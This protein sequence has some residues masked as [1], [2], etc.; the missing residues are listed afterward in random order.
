MALQ[1]G[2]LKGG[3]YIITNAYYQNNVS[4]SADGS[5]VSNTIPGYEDAPTRKMLWTVTLLLNGSYSIRNSLSKD[6][7]AIGPAVPKLGD[8]IVAKQEEQ[9]WEIKETGVKTRYVIS[10]DAYQ[11]LFWGLRSKEIGTQVT[12]RPH[13]TNSNNQWKFHA[14]AGEFAKPPLCPPSPIIQQN[15]SG[16]RLGKFAVRISFVPGIF[17]Y[18]YQSISRGPRSKD[19]GTQVILQPH[20]TNISNQR[21]SRARAGQPSNPTLCPPTPHPT[22]SNNL[23]TPTVPLERMV[24]PKYYSFRVQRKHMAIGS[25][26]ALYDHRGRFPT[27]RCIRPTE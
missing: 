11:S 17:R 24:N 18:I 13:P 7:Y 16:R 5:I 8:A 3:V 12:L 21:E 27:R 25:R 23:R 10:R 6:T 19:V 20:P 14:W 4:L 22:S 15:S 1:E 9:H 26:R 2:T